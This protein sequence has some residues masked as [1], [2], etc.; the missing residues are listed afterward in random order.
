MVLRFFLVSL[1][2]FLISNKNINLTSSKCG[3]TY[4]FDGV[5]YPRWK[6]RRRREV[7]VHV[8]GIRAHFSPIL[9]SKPK[10]VLE[11]KPDLGLKHLDR[12]LHKYIATH[13]QTEKQSKVV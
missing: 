9:S 11:T 13:S 10:T 1:V 4:R 5:Y 8:G 6:E 7:F 3:A 12:R 2:N